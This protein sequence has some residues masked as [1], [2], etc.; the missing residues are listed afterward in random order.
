[1]RL[2][3]ALPAVILC[4]ST[5][6]LSSDFHSAEEQLMLR[7]L[8]HATGQ[9]PVQYRRCVSATFKEE[10]HSVVRNREAPGVPSLEHLC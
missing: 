9:S 8:R 7:L 4:T 1:M 6:S 3:L 5:E 2:I 10:L